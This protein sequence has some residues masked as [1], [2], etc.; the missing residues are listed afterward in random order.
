MKHHINIIVFVAAVLAW[1]LAGWAL[2][3]KDPLNPAQLFMGMS[4]GLVVWIFTYWVTNW[5]GSSSYEALSDREH[6]E[7]TNKIYE[8]V[9]DDSKHHKITTNIYNVISKEYLSLV[10][11]RRK[12]KSS[13]FFSQYYESA[14]K[15]KISGLANRA[16][17]TYLFEDNCRSHSGDRHLLKLMEKRPIKV[18]VLMYDPMCEIVGE[19]D[20][21]EPIGSENQNFNNM[22]ETLGLI[23]KFHNNGNM[24]NFFK[25]SYLD[26][27][28]CRNPIYTTIFYA[29]S[30]EEY[31]GEDKDKYPILLMGMLY[32]Q[33][34]GDESQLF[35]VP[36]G[37]KGK[38]LFDDCLAN[39][40]ALFDLCR[41]ERFLYLSGGVNGS[42]INDPKFTQ[43]SEEGAHR[44]AKKAQITTKA[45][46]CG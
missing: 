4:G 32:I 43:I 9:S 24:P 19:M 33:K 6:Y 45:D 20:S 29:D 28:L 21:R 2:S 23:H 38:S 12:S 5:I 36:Q 16:F 1:G 31:T 22:T 7:T 26:I 34:P 25:G 37:D 42:Y 44:Y 30:D 11:E 8:A 35:K 46:I 13:D 10:D 39:F 14:N 18:E 17:I 41:K 3:F 27:R 40:D 15:I